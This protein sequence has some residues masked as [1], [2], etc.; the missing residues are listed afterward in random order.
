MFKKL[1]IIKVVVQQNLIK[2]KHVE[3]KLEEKEREIIKELEELFV[4]IY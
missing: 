4:K 2:E 3:I 1:C